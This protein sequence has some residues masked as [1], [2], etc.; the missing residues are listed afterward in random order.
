MKKI[1][2]IILGIALIVLLT[3]GI[4]KVKNNN[5]PSNTNSIQLETSE[6]IKQLEDKVERQEI[7]NETK[8]EIADMPAEVNT[9]Q[10]EERSAAQ[11]SIANP[12]KYESTQYQ[13]EQVIKS[14]TENENTKV[15]EIQSK[16][17]QVQEE[18]QEQKPS[19][20]TFTIEVDESKKYEIY[21][22]D[23]DEQWAHKSETIDLTEEQLKAMNFNY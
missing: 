15:L 14:S 8:E 21:N 20:N 12:V 10:S 7:F 1:V 18:K 5:V 22:Q 2:I 6:E 11:E 13:E 9:E 4:I 17:E 23:I 3:F 16:S 19:T